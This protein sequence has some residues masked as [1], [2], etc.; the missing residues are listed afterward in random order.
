MRTALLHCFL[1]ASIINSAY[2]LGVPLLTECYAHGTAPPLDAAALSAGWTL[3]EF[4]TLTQLELLMFVP[5]NLIA[6][7]AIPPRVRHRQIPTLDTL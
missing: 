6:F 2:L 1:V 3:D 7:R 4:I 5:Y